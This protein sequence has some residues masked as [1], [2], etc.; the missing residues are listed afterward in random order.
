MP[1]YCRPFIKHKHLFVFGFFAGRF[2]GFFAV[3]RKKC[4]IFAGFGRF[5]FFY[6]LD[7][8]EVG[9]A[10][11]V[12]G[13]HDYDARSRSAVNRDLAHRGADYYA[14]FGDEHTVVVVR[15]CR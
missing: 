1:F 3:F 4:V 5:F 15:S 12:G 13:T 10:G 14:R 6:V 7:H 11:V 2:C 9:D 8:G